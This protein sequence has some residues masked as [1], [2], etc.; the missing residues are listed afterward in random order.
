M[1]TAF[2]TGLKEDTE[3]GR[4]MF[5]TLCAPLMI[6]SKKRTSA[7]LLVYQDMTPRFRGF[8]KT[9]PSSLI[10]SQR[11]NAPRVQISGAFSP[12]RFT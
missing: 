5:R 11:A 4:E 2:L 6:S 3:G 9:V 1:V 10:K 8:S 7:V 12:R